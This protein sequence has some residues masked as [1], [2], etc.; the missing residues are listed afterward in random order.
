MKKHLAVF[1][2]AAVCLCT[3]PQ[4]GMSIFSNAEEITQ[5]Q[6]RYSEIENGSFDCV[7]Y[8]DH[9]EI[10][11]FIAGV[12]ACIPEEISGVPVTSIADGAFSG[13]ENHSLRSVI[14][15]ASI[16]TISE[17]AFQGCDRLNTLIL[18][19]TLECIESNA[20]DGC[21][22]LQDVFYKGDDAGWDEVFIK[23]GNEPLKNACMHTN[24]NTSDRLDH[25]FSIEEDTWSFTSNDLAAYTM[26]EESLTEY[27]ADCHPLTLATRV[28][29]HK[30]QS[31]YHDYDDVCSGFALTSYLVSVGALKPSDIYDGAETLHEIPLCEEA[32][33]AIYYYWAFYPYEDLITLQCDCNSD[34]RYQESG[35]FQKDM[36]QG[37]AV[38]IT[39]EAKQSEHT[40]IAYGIEEGQ[41]KYN[42]ITYNTRLLTYDSNYLGFADDACIYFNGDFEDMYIPYLDSEASVSDFFY[43]A[44]RLPYGIGNRTTYLSTYVLGDMNKDGAINASDAAQILIA[45]ANVGAGNESGLNNGQTYAA[46][47]NND[48]TFN[49]VDAARVLMY[50]AYVGSGG[51]QSFEEYLS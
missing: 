31:A 8:G 10:T 49:A 15:P 13:N 33:N 44:D 50:A 28:T 38:M 20:F 41:W 30:N 40:A 11:E 45:A 35:E 46:D 32:V 42:D 23:T 25:N 51:E 47:I 1:I 4:L 5:E 26:S 19:A 48:S 27:L 14:L 17:N 7:N 21:S 36:E 16:T 22:G 3:V 2:A 9:I 34:V 24:Y 39:Y 37:K 43:E 12:V 6:F 18:P 29:Y